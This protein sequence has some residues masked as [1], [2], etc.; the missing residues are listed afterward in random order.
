MTNRKLAYIVKDQKPLVL[1]AHDTVQLACRCMW[2]CRAGSVLVIDDQQRLSGI[3]TGRDAVRT[4]AEGKDAAVTTLAQAMTPNPVTIT[5]ENR[6]IDALRAMSDGGF[7]HLPVIED[8]R[9]WGIVSR[10]DF[11]G[12]RSIGWM[13]KLI[14]GN[15]FAD[16]QR[17]GVERRKSPVRELGLARRHDTG[18]W[19]NNRAE[20]S[21]QPLRTT[22]TTDE[23]LQVTRVGT[24]LSLNPRRRLQYAA[25]VAWRLT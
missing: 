2:E 24:A 1:A 4:L 13:R 17:H 19:K 16:H 8:G 14:C 21:H 5:P 11:T 15:A 12:M 9:I 20:N 7:R 6:A 3:F 18:R 22:R 23:A 10:G 25:T